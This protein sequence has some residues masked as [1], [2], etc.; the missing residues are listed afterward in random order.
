MDKSLYDLK[1]DNDFK[2]LIRPLSEEEYLQL[3]KNIKRDGCREP[4]VVWEDT[5]VD[6][7]NRYRICKKH[8]IPFAVHQISFESKDDAV[9]WICVN[10]LGRR[11]ISEE[12]RKYLIGI[13]YEKEKIVN[14]RKNHA[15]HNQYSRSVTKDVA[16]RGQ[17]TTAIRIAREN[18]V[19]IGTVQKYAAY[20]R[21]LNEIEKKNPKMFPKILSGKYRLSH[22]NTVELSKLA[23]EQI[24]GVRRKL[25]CGAPTS[26]RFS[27]CHRTVKNAAKRNDEQPPRPSVKDMPTYD[28]D[29][30]I[31]GLSFTIPSWIGS[32][33]RIINK[34]DIGKVSNEAKRVFSNNLN[35]LIETVEII[36]AFI[37]EEK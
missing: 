16:D 33:E 14:A 23:P 15:G 7:H 10:Q 31:N 1:V 21:A 28:P 8:G 22:D 11:N 29:A 2:C 6:G 4:L 30:E 20:A 9:I 34:T 37:E 25:D 3:E 32:I 24:E 27:K 18:N 12:T 36:L 5:I 17:H 19:S 26:A 35:K 13:Q